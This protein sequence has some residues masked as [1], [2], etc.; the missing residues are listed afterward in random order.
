MRVQRGRQLF[1]KEIHITISQ[2]QK[3][4][5]LKLLLQLEYAVRHYEPRPTITISEPVLWLSSKN[6]L[7]RLHYSSCHF[8]ET[9]NRH[10][11]FHCEHEIFRKTGKISDILKQ[12][13][14]T[15]FFRCNNS[16]IVNLNY[17]SDIMPEGNR[18]NIRLKSGEVIPLS[19]SRYQE[20]RKR[21]ELP[22]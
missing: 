12:L 10:L 6:R 14:E 15:I 21:L 20:C 22:G 1:M 11:I 7:H 13:P 8:I 9:D 5:C 16:Y 18:Y 2:L 3:K 4:D 17:I 19:R